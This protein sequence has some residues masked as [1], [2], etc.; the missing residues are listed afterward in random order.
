MR[1]VRTSQVLGV[2]GSRSLWGPRVSHGLVGQPCTFP[3]LSELGWLPAGGLCSG[4]A[5]VEGTGTLVP[6]RSRGACRALAGGL[7][8]KVRPPSPTLASNKGTQV[9]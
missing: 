8:D 7:W 6:W 2:P 5:G 9:V 4:G 3:S 1:S